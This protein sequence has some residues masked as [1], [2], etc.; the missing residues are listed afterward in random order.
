MVIKSFARESLWS[1][2]HQSQGCLIAI[3]FVLLER[4]GFLPIFLEVEVAFGVEP[5]CQ[6]LTIEDVTLIS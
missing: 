5:Y 6:K 2:N 1:I 4:G 3:K